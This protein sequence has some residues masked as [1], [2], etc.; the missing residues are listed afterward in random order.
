MSEATSPAAGEIK[1]YCVTEEEWVAAR[2]MDEAIEFYER[3][4]GEEVE[5]EYV[6]EMTAND[7]E[8]TPFEYYGVS[9]EIETRPFAEELRD[10]IERGYSFPHRFAST[11]W[12]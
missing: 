10:R 11:D 12:R 9:R 4:T 6:T 8:N 7:L 3:D 1:V 2:S 5:R